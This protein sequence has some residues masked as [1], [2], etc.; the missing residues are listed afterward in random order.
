M[1]L[2]HPDPTG[3]FA[4]MHLHV[5][6]TYGDPGSWGH[7]RYV[8]GTKK[9]P[10]RRRIPPETQNHPT[11]TKLVRKIIRHGKGEQTLM[12]LRYAELT[13]KQYGAV[14]V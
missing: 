14:D 5:R 7:G 9:G 2:P 4:L 11:G 12:R 1:K 13:G 3:F 8:N 10:G 6:M